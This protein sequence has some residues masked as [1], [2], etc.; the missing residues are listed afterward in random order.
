[1]MTKRNQAR[2]NAYKRRYRALAKQLADVGYIASGSVASRYNKC[3]KPNCACHNDPPTLHGPYWQWTAK[4]D[5]KTVNRRLTEQQA[6]LYNEWIANDRHVR[7][8]LTQMRTIAAKAAE[9][10]LAENQGA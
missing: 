9:I 8:L 2:L 1:M 6:D 7:A 10:I 3:G 4:V 5:G